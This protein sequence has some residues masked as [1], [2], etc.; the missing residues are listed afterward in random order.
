MYELLANC[1]PP[2]LIIKGLVNEVLKKLDDEVK[3]VRRR[4]GREGGGEREGGSSAS[5]NCMLVVI[6]CMQG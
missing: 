1:I 4:R 5:I 3:R 2:E 6:A